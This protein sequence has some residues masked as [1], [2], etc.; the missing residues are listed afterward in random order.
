MSRLLDTQLNYL[1]DQLNPVKKKKKSQETTPKPEVAQKKRDITLD[2][3]PVER[4]VILKWRKI[5]IVLSSS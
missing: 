1:F 4:K 3:S 2:P 5:I